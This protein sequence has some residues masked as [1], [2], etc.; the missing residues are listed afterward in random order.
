MERASILTSRLQ[1]RHARSGLSVAIALW[2]SGSAA[3]QVVP[4]EAVLTEAVAAPVPVIAGAWAQLFVTTSVSDVPV[5]GH[6]RSETR[7]LLRLDIEQVGAVATIRS[8]VCDIRVGGSGLVRTVI[9]DALVEAI[10]PRSNTVVLTNDG[11]RTLVS[12]W[13]QL[14]VLGADLDDPES[15]TLPMSPDDPRVS[16]PDGDGNPGI[17]VL[18][19]G[20]VSGDIYLVQRGFSR[21]S[22]TVVNSGELHGTIVWDQEQHIL[23]A[24]TGVLRSAPPTWADPDAERNWFRSIPIDAASSCSDIVANSDRWFGRP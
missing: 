20:F 8:R 23:D 15:D 5:L 17:T 16:D 18:V 14:Q 12:G 11:G 24:T 19:R 21:L 4:S 6:I 13:E 9:P 7:T 3:A 10:D 2:L 1:R 22:A